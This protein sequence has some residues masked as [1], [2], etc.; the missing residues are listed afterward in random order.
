VYVPCLQDA[1][2]REILLLGGVIEIPRWS[3]TEVAALV[4]IQQSAKYRWRVKG[5]PI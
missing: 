5:W 1:G 2:G 3:D 4:L